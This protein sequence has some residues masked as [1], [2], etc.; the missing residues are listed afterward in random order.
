MADK[1]A[2]FA[3]LQDFSTDEGLSLH[4]AL[5]GDASANKNAHGAFVATDASG[6]FQYMRVNSNNEL[7]VDTESAAVACLSESNSTA[8]NKV[9]EQ[10]VAKVTLQSSKEYNELSIVG[11]CF[12]EAQFRLVAVDDVGVTDVE[13]E[14]ARFKVGPGQYSFQA[15]GKCLAFTSG[16]TGVQELQVLAI[17]L[18]A[19]SDFD[20]T[21]SAEEVQ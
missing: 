16:S 8:G 17:N 10:E 19:A 6:D 15:D 12:R 1:R 13:T 3:T 20:G 9:T 21:I 14:I 2:A 11:S 5:E 18:N 7:I 4:K